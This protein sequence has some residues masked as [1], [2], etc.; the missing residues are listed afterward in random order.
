M[1]LIVLLLVPVLSSVAA[2]VIMAVYSRSEV[3]QARDDVDRHNAHRAGNWGLTYA[4][5][6]VLLVAA[7]IVGLFVLDG[8]PILDGFWPYGLILTTW[9]VWSVVHVA[10]S[11]VG[12]IVARKGKLMPVNGI[13]FFRQR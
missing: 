1:G 9:L 3:K 6:T 11:I 7:H 10:V 2:G 8:H 12:I 4:I 5:G 13:P